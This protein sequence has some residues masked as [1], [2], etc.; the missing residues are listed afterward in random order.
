MKFFDKNCFKNK[1]NNFS[2]LITKQT[3]YYPRYIILHLTE[4]FQDYDVS[5]YKEDNIRHFTDT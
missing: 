2:D 4:A 1:I 3:K 5:V